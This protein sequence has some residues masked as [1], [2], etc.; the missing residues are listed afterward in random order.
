M[1]RQD[2]KIRKLRSSDFLTEKAKKKYLQDLQE[3]KKL[4][5]KKKLE[6]AKILDNTPQETI[7]NHFIEILYSV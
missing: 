3:V 1:S 5:E 6:L 7:E 4:T 2:H